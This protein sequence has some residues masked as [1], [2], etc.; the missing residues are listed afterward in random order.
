MENMKFG[1]LSKLAWYLSDIKRQFPMLKGITYLN[2]ALAGPP[3]LSVTNAMRKSIENWSKFGLL[4]NDSMDDI[5]EIKKGFAELIGAHATEIA[6]VPSVSAGLI[7]IASSL[8]LSGGKKNVVVS[9]LNFTANKVVWQRMR[10]KGL[11]KNVRLLE[12]ENGELPSD[13]YE[14]SVD[15]NTA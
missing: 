6:I 2:S 10:E 13:S 14:K 9:S 5:V 12:A 7:A 4:W 15:D 11:F 1:Y 8:D 3:P